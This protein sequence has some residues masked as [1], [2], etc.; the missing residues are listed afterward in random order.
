MDRQLGRLGEKVALHGK[1]T[2][3]PKNQDQNHKR[4]GYN[5]HEGNHFDE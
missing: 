1:I 4:D 3:I 2:G 5:H